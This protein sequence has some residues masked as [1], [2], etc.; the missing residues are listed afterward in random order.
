MAIAPAGLLVDTVWT[1]AAVRYAN[2]LADGETVYYYI[3]QSGGSVSYDDGETGISQGHTDED[4][5]YIRSIFQAIDPYIDLDFQESLRTHNLYEKRS[6]IDVYALSSFSAWTD[7]TLGMCSDQRGYWNVNWRDT[8]TV[9]Y[10]L[11]NNDKN[12]IVH[13]IGHALGLDHPFGEGYNSDY[14]Q[15]DTVMS[16]NSG[17]R[18]FWA[19]SFT[20]SDIQALQQ[21]WGVEDDVALQEEDDL[22]V[23]E[24][25][26]LVVYR[27]R[28]DLTGKFIFS[29]NSVEIDIITGQGWVNE[30]AAYASP[31]NAT[32]DLHRFMMANG[33]HFYTSN[34]E[35]KNIL[36][37]DSSF[38]Y[39]GV[40]YQVYST[41]EP[42]Q[43]AISVV[44]YLSN[45]GSHLYSTSQLEQDILDA[46]DQWHNEGIAWYGES[47]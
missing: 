13:E 29:A 11:I 39:E 9:G 40:A 22:A 41:A 26:D 36:S 25:D 19:T 17:P 3:H 16:Y 42:P 44:R 31:A 7:T 14:D 18:G 10:G 23:Q 35:E 8:D 32:A 5:E 27:L 20:T 6:F 2:N 21:I 24:E 34:I 38:T 37:Q 12:T 1:N 33:G 28:N 47:I 15:E 43:G 45:A 46:S 30:G 4:S